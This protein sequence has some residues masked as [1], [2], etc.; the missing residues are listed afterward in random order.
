MLFVMTIL[1]ADFNPVDIIQI[2]VLTALILFL[3]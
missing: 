2:L 1:K 3:Q